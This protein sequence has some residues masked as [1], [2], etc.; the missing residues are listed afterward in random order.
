MDVTPPV[1]LRPGQAVRLVG[2]GHLGRCGTVAFSIDDQQSAGVEVWVDF[3]AGVV[4]P[5]ERCRM[6][7]L[8]VVDDG[9]PDPAPRTPWPPLRPA[10]PR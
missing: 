3:G 6:E 5:V 10:E 1:D 9:G 2:R 4:V 7:P 8:A